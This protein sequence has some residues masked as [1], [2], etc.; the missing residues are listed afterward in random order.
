MIEFLSPYISKT[1]I[2]VGIP[3]SS[4]SKFFILQISVILCLLIIVIILKKEVSW[5]KLNWW[6]VSGIVIFLFASSLLLF[7][8]SQLT[9][10]KFSID[11]YSK[12]PSDENT[13]FIIKEKCNSDYIKPIKGDGL[14]CQLEITPIDSNIIITK[15]LLSGHLNSN[16]KQIE[17]IQNDGKYVANYFMALPNASISKHQYKF[18]YYQNNNLKILEIPERSLILIDSAIILSIQEQRN[19]TLYTLLFIVLSFSLLSIFIG[20][21]AIK[22]LCDNDQKKKGK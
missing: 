11:Y 10:E 3:S 8:T 7:F 14:N 22:D 17:F 13:L 12:L 19:N 1:L 6:V 21:K 20:I 18:Y 4:I 16:Y 15:L 2:N 9:T 5:F